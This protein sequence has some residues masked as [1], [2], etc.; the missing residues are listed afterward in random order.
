MKAKVT[1]VARV[2]DGTRK[3]PFLTVTIRRNSIVLPVQNG[4][5]AYEPDAILG[6]Y[7]RYPHVTGNCLFPGCTGTVARHVEPLGKDHVEA[8]AKYQRIERDFSRVRDGKLPLEDPKLTAKGRS[9]EECV[10]S[11]EED[12]KNKQRK[13]RTLE[14]YMTSLR[15]F[16]TFCA[17]TGVKSIDAVD[18]KVVLGFIG[19]MEKNLEKRQGGHPN[20]T[21]RNKLKD[22]SIFLND[23]SVVMPLKR[24]DWPKEVKARKEKYSFDA[25]KGM[26]KATKMKRHANNHW[27]PE[28]DKDLIHFLMKTGFRDEE[29]MHAQYSDISFKNATVNVT[30]KPKGSFP[31]FPELEW[32]PK[33]NEAREKD[34]VVDDV[35]LKRMENRKA[36]YDAKSSSLIF[37][38]GKGKP[39]HHLIRVLQRL[40]KEAGIEGRIG[41][42]KFR[43]TFATM[44]A[45]D[46]GIEQARLL[47]GHNDIATTQKYLAADEI[48]PAQ[49]RK[50]VS[51]RYEA[52]G[53]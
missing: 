20:N 12:L 17:E 41:L 4:H 38:N 28:D 22:L 46:E 25:V 37:P 35:F 31:G 42:H 11:F 44:V 21:Y 19:W 43:K 23:F 34:I 26:I 3:F 14:S 9:L 6:F 48:T 8:Y 18:K 40:A 27:S 10:N 32:T 29:I 5:R 15:N 39:N 33:D 7:A 52:L 13:G 1:L 2:N 47:L 36:R 30:S 53:D 45:K 24:K 49:S 51:K 50:V 16:L